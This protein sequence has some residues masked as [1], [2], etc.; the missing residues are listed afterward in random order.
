MSYFLLTS[1]KKTKKSLYVRLYIFYV[2]S[3]I[4][5]LTVKRLKIFL[6]REG[7]MV[8]VFPLSPS[9]DMMKESHGYRGDTQILIV[10]LCMFSDVSLS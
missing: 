9:Q 8:L 4:T 5:P 2:R 3:Q 1:V 10:Q 6:Y 7:Y